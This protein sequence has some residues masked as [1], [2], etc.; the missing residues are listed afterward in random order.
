MEEYDIFDESGE[1]L[2]RRVELNSD[3]VVH[4]QDNSA[5]GYF[6]AGEFSE[7]VDL[8]IDEDVRVFARDAVYH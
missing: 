4:I 8:G 1:C 2:A 6:R 5:D 3:I 7:L